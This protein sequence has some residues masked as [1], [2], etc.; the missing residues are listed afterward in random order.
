LASASNEFADAT[1]H[2]SAV[3]ES[4][5]GASQSVAGG[6]REQAGQ[7]ERATT[8][9]EELARSATQIASGAAD[10]ALAV[11]S[12]VAEAR[13]VDVGIAGVADRGRK[14]HEFVKLASA[15]AAGGVEAVSK[16]EKAVI[17]LRDQLAANEIVMT[18]LE[19]R[20]GAV[21]EIVK[22]IDEIAEQT[23][24][25]ALNAAIEAARAG[26]QGRGFAVVANEVRKLAE[27]SATSTR[28]IGG[29]L[30]TIRRETV[31]AANSMRVSS[32]SMHAGL[33]LA[34]L[35]RTALEKLGS[36]ID[37]TSRLGDA[38]AA[39]AETMAAASTRAAASIAGVSAITEQ[40]AA[41][42]A[43]VGTTTGYVSNSL[44]AV[45]SSSQ[46]QSGAASDVSASVLS[47]AA[48]V[49]E[50]HATAGNVRAEAA[51]LQAIVARFRIDA[52]NSAP[53]AMPALP[54]RALAAGAFVSARS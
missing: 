25:L 5:S 11:R 28:E 2:A 4:I 53:P 52:Q 49:G 30:A 13:A 23:N 31:E 54:A 50:M 34:T 7:I 1:G 10:Q 48:Q 40:N 44:V 35:A 3:V 38:M 37:E 15:E 51:T 39:G 9:V 45:R 27:R 42:A 19:S 32:S 12:V 17:E 26:E 29:I 16:T 46:I 33:E 36:R 47:L 8:A 6:T 41:A 43:E 21:N 18:S 22:V 20:S 24:L 14:M